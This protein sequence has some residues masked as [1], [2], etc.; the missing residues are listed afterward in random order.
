HHG[1]VP[2]PAGR[3]RAGQPDGALRSERPSPVP[4]QC[5]EPARQDLLQ[6]DRLLQPVPLRRA[7]QLHA[8]RDLS[9]LMDDAPLYLAHASAVGGIAALRLAW[10]RK[11]RSRALNGAGWAL[12]VLG[13]AL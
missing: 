1:P 2:D 13:A 3:L 8:R 12:L 6:P 9:V 7:A 4:G 5:R 10:S 11:Q